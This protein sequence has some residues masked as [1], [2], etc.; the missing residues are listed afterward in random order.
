MDEASAEDLAG[1]EMATGGLEPPGMPDPEPEILE[2]AQEILNRVSEGEAFSS[3]GPQP[4]VESAGGF[5]AID[6]Q[7]KL[8]FLAHILG[9]R[10][11]EKWF[12][13]FGGR[14]QLCF[15]SIPARLEREIKGLLLE[16]EEAGLGTPTDRRLRYDGYMLAAS[17]CRVKLDGGPNTR[18]EVFAESADNA[19]RQRAYRAWFSEL[20]ADHYRLIRTC[21]LHFRNHISFLMRKAEDADFWPTPS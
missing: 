20:D 2:R 12:T 1:F 17:L 8:T 7:E 11:F 10:P 21:Y 4:E 16:E 18:I 5:D 6:D 3:V 13:L 14:F 15:R 19:D 9:N